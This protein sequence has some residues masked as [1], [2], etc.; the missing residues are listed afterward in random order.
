M[1]YDDFASLAY[2]QSIRNRAKQDY[3]KAYAW[4]LKQGKT[5]ARPERGKLSYMAAQAVMIRLDGLCLK[6]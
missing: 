3:A 5:G 1:Q 4:Y 6:D 2:I